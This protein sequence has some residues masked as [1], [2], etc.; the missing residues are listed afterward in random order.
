MVSGVLENEC[1]SFDK[2]STG[3]ASQSGAADI[4]DWIPESNSCTG[5]TLLHVVYLPA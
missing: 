3:L 1:S 2:L 5:P 4:G